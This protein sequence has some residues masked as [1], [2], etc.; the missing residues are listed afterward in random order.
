[1]L[2]VAC[3]D[4]KGLKLWKLYPDTFFLFQTTIDLDVVDTITVSVAVK[5]CQIFYAF[6]GK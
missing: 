5:S 2:S 6:E 3:G 1:M 4:P